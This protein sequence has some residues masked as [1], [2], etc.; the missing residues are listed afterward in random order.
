MA[1]VL[2]ISEQYYGPK[3]CLVPGCIKEGRDPCV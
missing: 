3:L 2:H 1:D